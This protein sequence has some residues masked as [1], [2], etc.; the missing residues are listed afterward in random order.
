MNW[1]K[2]VNYFFQKKS[3]CDVKMLDFVTKAKTQRNKF[4]YFFK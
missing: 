3:R 2:N 1:T 4:N